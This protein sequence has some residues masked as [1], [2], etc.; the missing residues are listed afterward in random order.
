[1]QASIQQFIHTLV[2]EATKQGATCSSRF[3]TINMNTHQFMCKWAFS[4]VEDHSTSWAFYYKSLHEKYRDI[5]FGNYPAYSESCDT[6]LKF[7]G[8]LAMN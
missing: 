6:F 3:I 4:L 8:I 7:L 1:M 5:C 2:A